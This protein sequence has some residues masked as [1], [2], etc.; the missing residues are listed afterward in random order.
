MSRRIFDGGPKQESARDDDQKSSQYYQCSDFDLL[1]CTHAEYVLKHLQHR[2]VSTYKLYFAHDAAF[3]LK[4]FQ[5]LLA[6]T[7]E[8]LKIAM[9]CFQCVLQVH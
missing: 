9:L 6:V 3:Q 8:A 7:L 4:N 2:K 5:H 1:V